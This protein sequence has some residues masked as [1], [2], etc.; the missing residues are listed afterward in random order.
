MGRENVVWSRSGHADAAAAWA[1]REPPGLDVLRGWADG[2]LEEQLDAFCGA[3][4]A[5]DTGGA[6]HPDAVLALG[7]RV[8]DARRVGWRKSRLVGLRIDLL[9]AGARG[10]LAGGR[11]FGAAW[12]GLIAEGIGGP[13]P[14]PTW[15]A[16]A[17]SVARACPS[18]PERTSA[19]LVAR[20]RL[21]EALDTAR[22]E[23]SGGAHLALCEAALAGDVEPLQAA[24]HDGPSLAL[25]HLFAHGLP[26]RRA[27][28]RLPDL[29]AGLDP[30]VDALDDRGP[31]QGAVEDRLLRVARPLEDAVTGP[32]ATRGLL[33]VGAVLRFAHQ[34][35]RPAVVR[36][37]LAL[38][39]D[40]SARVSDGHSQDVYRTATDIVETVDLPV[41][42]ESS[43]ARTARTLTLLTELGAAFGAARVRQ[44]FRSTHR[45]KR[46]TDEEREALG[47]VFVRHARRMKGPL[48]KVAQH[49]GYGGVPLSPRVA[50]QLAALCDR[51]PALPFDRVHEV[52]T[53]ELGDPRRIFASIEPVPLGT[54]SVGQV[55]GARL[56]DGR[57][58]A[59]KVLYPG[60]RDAIRHDVRLLGMATP[61]L[62]IL[63]PRTPW[64]DVVDE[65]EAEL[66]GE[67]DLHR[68]AELQRAFAAGFADDPHV[69]VPRPIDGMV[70]ERVLVM[71]RAVGERLEPF[72][73]S[74]DRASRQ[75]ATDAL[76]RFFLRDIGANALYADFNPG[77]VLFADDAVWC[78]D[79]GCVKRWDDGMHVKIRAFVTGAVLRDPARFRPAA[80][81]LDVTSDP[82][83]FDYDRLLA[84]FDPETY[85]RTDAAGRPLPF[86]P[87]DVFRLVAGFRLRTDQTLQP[88][89][90]FGIRAYFSFIAL[91]VHLGCSDTGMEVARAVIER[92]EAA[93]P[94]PDAL[95]VP[96]PTEATR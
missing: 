55:H 92:A 87:H 72:A 67:T 17:L 18:A 26:E 36:F 65:L 66:L 96:L 88:Y 71:D 52:L 50:R 39:H 19:G 63:V 42:A 7:L 95:D 93:T 61:L 4:R 21:L 2:T 77:N 10:L 59:V 31:A 53:D 94:G 60:I 70:T 51:S 68:E 13:P 11:P 15:L 83:H 32:D 3:V 82:D 5:L 28:H 86:E 41:L 34:A 79:F 23:A 69:R 74:A 40:W 89:H 33:A 75:R 54:G 12:L 90:L 73:A 35:R 56:H 20:G 64:G 9:E 62:R 37:L 27:S 43:W 38:L 6:D 24:S 1:S 8:L 91:V 81:A 44:L 84:L 16:S 45:A 78:M 25:A 48:M 85:R 46:L 22:R 47:R 80:R 58:V 76:Y 30:L 29:A 49:M 57:E 14:D